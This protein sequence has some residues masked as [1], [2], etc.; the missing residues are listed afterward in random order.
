GTTGVVAGDIAHHATPVFDRGDTA[1]YARVLSGVGAVV[2]K[3]TNTLILTG[4]NTHTGSPP[5][6]GGE[7]RIGNGGA[8]GSLAGDI[9]NAGTLT[10]DR[11]NAL[12][13]TGVISGPGAVSKIGADAVNLA[14]ANTYDGDTTVGAGTLEFGRA[15]GA[16]N[17]LGGGITVAGGA[18]LAIHTPATVD[19]AGAVV[20]NDGASLSITTARAA[21]GEP[22]ESWRVKAVT[23]G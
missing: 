18:T 23:I 15:L 4:G 12:T 9:A 5:I 3:G 7:L 2:K 6:E 16:A 20:L 8:T 1:T 17:T 21:E 22:P 11:G 10:F 14:G 13:Y 19:M